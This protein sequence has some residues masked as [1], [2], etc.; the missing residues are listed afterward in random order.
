MR[1]LLWFTALASGCS[2]GL[3]NYEVLTCAT[4]SG[5]VS[6]QQVT[7]LGATPDLTLGT[8]SGRGFLAAFVAPVQ[9]GSCVQAVDPGGLVGGGCLFLA[10]DL[11]AVPRQPMVASLGPG[12]AGAL[13]RT[14]APCTDGML[15]VH[16]VA[17][18]FDVAVDLACHGA[19]AA[20]GAALP[21]IAAL[22]ATRALVA[23]YD[24]PLATRDN[25]LSSCDGA[26]GAPL[27]IALVSPTSGAPF[28]PAV[29]LASDG[30]SVRPPAL[31]LDPP[32]GIFVVAPTADSVGIWQLDA[33]LQVTAT[34]TIDALAGARAVA[35]AATTVNGTR[36]L[37]IAAEIGCAPQR[38]AVAVG[39]L[40]DGFATFDATDGAEA[41]TV[42]P[43][44]AWIDA[45]S[46]FLVSWIVG[47]AHPHVQARRFTPDARP[48]HAAIDIPLPA[49]AAAV[50]SDGDII[51]FSADNTFVDQSLGCDP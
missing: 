32:D 21:A 41:V 9:G 2:M 22:D 23:W 47:G 11:A 5:A 38:I 27:E 40:T 15:A 48:V 17:P 36:T 31:V 10:R 42:Q 35:A 18:G 37:A 43:S 29:Q 39:D 13:V 20:T 12:E 7:S 50:T 44:V 8:A 4:P 3:G 30:I 19:G 28:P 1:A 33:N 6:T 34:A 26:A 51:A 49:T 46:E 16:Y 24:T 14:T 45:R 25:P